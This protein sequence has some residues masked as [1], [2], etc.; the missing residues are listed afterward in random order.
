MRLKW[1][2]LI[3]VVALVGVLPGLARAQNDPQAGAPPGERQFVTARASLQVPA[4]SIRVT[5]VDEAGEPVQ[6]AEVNI[7]L[8]GAAGDRDRRRKRTDATGITT[9]R[10]LPTGAVEAYRVNLPYGGALYSSTPFRLPPAAGFDVRITRLP[11]T[12]E[13]S[14]VVL[15][16]GELS[17]EFR[18]GRLHLSQSVQLMNVGQATYVFPADGLLIELPHGFTAPQTEAVMTDQRLLGDDRG[19][20]LSGS[21]PPGTVVLSWAYQL[22]LEGAEQVIE[23][24]VPFRTYSYRVVTDAPDGALLDVEAVN[25]GRTANGAPPSAFTR[26]EVVES[27]G[28]RLFLSDLER[29]QDDPPLQRVRIHFSGLPTPGPLRWVAV[30][31]AL[32]LSLIGVYIAVASG[33]AQSGD[34]LGTRKEQVLEALGALERQRKSEQLGPRTYEQE[35]EK[36]LVELAAVIRAEE[37]RSSGAKRKSGPGPAASVSSGKGAASR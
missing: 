1:R 25:R 19:Y 23:L 9:F 24:P 16:H 5:V 21:L 11:T 6:G 35:R 15:V 8:M 12:H 34:A 36:L 7:G 30:L 31:G 32:L 4:G 29:G 27:E 2:S 20:K 33:G 17:V 26:P 28:R 13:L 18:E 3:G 22:P 37:R 10:G 14:T